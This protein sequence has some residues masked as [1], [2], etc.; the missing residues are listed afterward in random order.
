MRNIM[1][2]TDGSP[3]ASRAIDVATELVKGLG[4]T[5][6]L[7]TAGQAVRTEEHIRYAI[8]EGDLA[9]AAETFALQIL[10]DAEQSLH[11]GTAAP[12]THLVW[13]DLPKR[14]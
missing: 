13:G 3:G 1:V 14:P 10:S 8:V 5:L 9:D 11:A 12:K 2:A 4:G 6:T 7:V